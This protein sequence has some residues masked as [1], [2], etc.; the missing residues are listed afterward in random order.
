MAKLLREAN[1]M[2][3]ITSESEP[4]HK[5]IQRNTKDIKAKVNDCI[6]LL[7]AKESIFWPGIT[8]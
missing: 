8:D 4:L 2:K 7:L 5:Q 1:A 3:M 6:L